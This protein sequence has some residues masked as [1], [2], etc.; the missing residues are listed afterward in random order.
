M[1]TNNGKTSFF[2]ATSG[3]C[4]WITSAERTKRTS[5]LAELKAML[6]CC[7]RQMKNCMTCIGV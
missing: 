1:L 5:I 2:I 3:S 7:Y 6:Y 4:Q